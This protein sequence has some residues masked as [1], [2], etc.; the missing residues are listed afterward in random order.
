MFAQVFRLL[1]T[2]SLIKPRKGSNVE[3]ADIL[4]TMLDFSDLRE[5]KT[6]EKLCNY[7]E[8]IISNDDPAVEDIPTLLEHNDERLNLSNGFVQGFIAGY[9][10]FKSKN[11]TKCVRCIESVKITDKPS[12]DDRHNLINAYNRGGLH[13]P[14]NELYNLTN[15]IE[16]IILRNVACGQLNPDTFLEILDSIRCTD[17]I[18]VGC[19]EHQIDF[20]KSIVSFYLI[21]RSHFIVKQYNEMYDENKQKSKKCRKN[22][23]L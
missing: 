22:A 3:G 14:S 17:V 20:T 12:E 7:L 13:Y 23:K 5:E 1:S 19:C 11:I 6:T 8:E 18:K 9:V 4:K 21:M 15:N 2:Y 10:A 16:N